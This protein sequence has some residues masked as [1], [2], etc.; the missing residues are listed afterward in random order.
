MPKTFYLICGYRGSG[1][2]TLFKWLMGDE[3]YT[4]KGISYNPNIPLDLPM[5]KNI[6]R[7][8]FAD[9]LKKEVL[10]SLNLPRFNSE[11][12]KDTPLEQIFNLLKVSLSPDIN[13][14][15]TLRDVY[16]LYAAQKKKENI[17]Y[18][19]E[20]VHENIIFEDENS[21]CYI[22]TDWRYIHEREYFL[23][24]GKVVTIRIYRKDVNVPNAE[25]ERNLDDF[26]TDWVFVPEKNYEIE[27]EHMHNQFPQ[28][29]KP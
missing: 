2:D 5:T 20:K 24:L 17:D 1:K 3:T 7:F 13:K 8:A 10:L 26:K 21:E 22:I 16:I 11:A 23:K 4:F 29:I 9:S 19:C 6:S 18:W 15:M 25:S 14:E 27:I 12:Y 28:Y